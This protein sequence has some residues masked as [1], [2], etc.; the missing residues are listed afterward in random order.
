MLDHPWETRMLNT[1][2]AGKVSFG[3]Q[4]DC[5]GLFL[6]ALHCSLGRPIRSRVAHWAVLD[7]GL[8]HAK[9]GDTVEEVHNGRLP[10]APKYHL[11]P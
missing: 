6:N 4:L 10:V 1:E 8:S 5:P 2:L 7:Q 11:A 9:V 3:G